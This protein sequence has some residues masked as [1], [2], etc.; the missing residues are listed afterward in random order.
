MYDWQH[1]KNHVGHHVGIAGMRR[2]PPTAPT[3]GSLAF[4]GLCCFMSGECFRLWPPSALRKVD[5][6][7]VYTQPRS[8]SVHIHKPSQCEMAYFR[9]PRGLWGLPISIH[10]PVLIHVISSAIWG[11]L[12][13]SPARCPL[14]TCASLWRCQT[15][16]RRLMGLT[17]KHFSTNSTH[18]NN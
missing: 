1:L 12:T 18:P 6:T 8:T 16:I 17:Q 5:T 9:L 14:T 4:D 15:A 11:P 7:M 3:H 13:L 10:N 2:P